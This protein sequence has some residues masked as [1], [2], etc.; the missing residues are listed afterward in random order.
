MFNTISPKVYKRIRER[1]GLSQ[2][3]L[4]DEIG[5]TRYT[6]SNFENG[7]SKPTAEQE[8]LVLEVCDCSTLEFAEMV[9]EELSVV[10]DAPVGFR[11]RE[12]GNGPGTLLSRANWLLLDATG[13]LSGRM[14]RGLQRRIT[15]LRLIGVT[16]DH[17]NIDLEE[18]M[19]ECREEMKRQEGEKQMGDLIAT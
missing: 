5:V 3:E 8:E 9:C 7:K 17:F 18:H 12:G 19:Q 11:S 15:Q 16:F 14:L 4:G 1:K 6:I 2:S 10:A 13:K